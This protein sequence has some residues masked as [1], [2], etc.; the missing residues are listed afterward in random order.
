MLQKE[1]YSR[2]LDIESQ[3]IANKLT[4]RSIKIWPLIR[5][6]LWIEL[7]KVT[8][9]GESSQNSI[10]FTLRQLIN[11]ISATVSTFRVRS[12]SVGS[13]T[14]AFISRPV[15]LEELPN[16]YFFDRIVDPLIFCMP[17]DSL[18]AKYYVAPWPKGAELNYPAALLRSNRSLSSKMPEIPEAH[19]AL[20]ALM[21]GD[22]GI[23]PKQLLWRYGKNLKEFDLWL[24]AARHFFDSRTN[25]KTVYLTS[26]YFPDMMAFVAAARERGIKTIDVQHGK[27]G[28]FQAMYSGWCIPEE[29][30]QMMPD[31]FW[32]WGKPSA[33]HILASSPDRRIHRP[34]IGGYPWL[35]F[36]RSYIWNEKTVNSQGKKKRVLITLQSPQAD[37]NQPIPQ[38]ILDFLRERKN[39]VYFIF[40]CHPND[41]NG[42]EY[43]RRR[44]SEI[45]S[46]LYNIDYGQSN[47]YDQLIRAS[48]HITAYSSCCYEASTFGVPTLLFGAD[49]RAIYSDEIESGLFSWTAGD[50]HYLASWLDSM[51]HVG[52]QKSLEYIKSSL[53]HTAKILRHVD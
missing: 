25:L 14:T 13:E 40:R 22:V 16:G 5:Q 24:Q 34:I 36:Y 12:S 53:V 3:G 18:H 51:N 33:E 52:D 39:E 26:W 47:L 43:C 45:P 23:E 6:C 9:R 1:T 41:Q 49:A 21:A 37:N 35:D 32:N 28:K 46:Y 8:L 10:G 30:Y 29:G 20:L 44:L 31:I 4:W 42:A 17:D 11:R 19:R 2:I 38:F 48:H 7:N 15:Y 27:Q 50:S